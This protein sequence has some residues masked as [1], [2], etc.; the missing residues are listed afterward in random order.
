MNALQAAYEVLT[1]RLKNANPLWGGRVQPLGV[2]SAALVK[3]YVVF[4]LAAGGN[5]EITPNRDNASFIISIKGV[6]EDMA[7][8]FAIDDT[9]NGLLND[10]GRQDTSPRLPVHAVW[11]I[12]NVTKGRMIYVE[13]KFSNAQSIYH[14]GHQYNVVMEHK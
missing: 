10:S 2:A 6:A 1:Q 13:E 11:D 4:S 8:A 5:D 14:A 9:V 7:T 12:L 3:P